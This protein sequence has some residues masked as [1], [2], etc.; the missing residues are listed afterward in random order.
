MRGGTAGVRFRES[1]PGQLAAGE[2][3]T[4]PR[5]GGESDGPGRSV[6]GTGVPAPEEG[7]SRSPHQSDREPRT[8]TGGTKKGTPAHRRA[9]EPKMS[10]RMSALCGFR[11]MPLRLPCGEFLL[12]WVAF[13]AGF[14]ACSGRSWGSKRVFAGTADPENR[15]PS[16]L[17]PPV[18]GRTMFSGA[19]GGFSRLIAGFSFVFHP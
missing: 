19:S 5:G 2:I 15:G 10:G 14:S 11:E 3:K 18:P 9:K 1:C 12:F 13:S 6:P 7:R 17:L 8:A 4:V 16:G